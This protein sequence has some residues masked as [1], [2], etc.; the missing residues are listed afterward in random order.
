MLNQ[1]G[2]FDYTSMKE[3]ILM[4]NKIYGVFLVCKCDAAVGHPLLHQVDKSWWQPWDKNPGSSLKCRL[5]TW[6]L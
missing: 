3:V 6:L 4:L 2:K 5:L 1:R